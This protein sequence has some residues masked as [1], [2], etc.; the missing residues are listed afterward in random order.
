MNKF[1]NKITSRKFLTGLSLIVSGLLLIFGFADS[2]A[3]TIAGAVMAIVGGVG[4]MLAEA[5]VDAK[6]VGNIADG[7]ELLVGAL[8]EGAAEG[9]EEETEI[10]EKDGE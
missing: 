5:K 8:L 1:I 10:T 3:E 7:L 4:Y 9:T 6:S 2:T